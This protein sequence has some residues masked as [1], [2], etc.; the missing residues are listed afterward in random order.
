MMH[1]Q[2]YPVL[3]A[4]AVIIGVVCIV[5]SRS[6]TPEQMID[7]RGNPVVGTVDS[8]VSRYTECLELPCSSG[9]AD[10]QVIE[11]EG[12]T[13]GWNA[14]RNIPNWVAYELTDAEIDGQEGRADSFRPDPAVAGCPTSGDYAHSGYDR[15][16]MAPAA[17]MKWSKQAMTESFYLTNVC[18]QNHN[19]NSGDWKTLE[20][21]VREWGGEYASVCV[22]TG[23]IVT[24]RH[25]ETIGRNCSIVVPDAFFKAVLLHNGR[26][27]Q[28]IAF[29][30]NNEP[31]RGKHGLEHYACSVDEIET[32]TGLDL[33][34]N[35][36]DSIETVV[37]SKCEPSAF[38][39]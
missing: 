33:F 25:P 14:R 12:Y 35:L 37:E 20:E 32:V 18:P 8:V 13:V 7:G 27:W 28:A 15:G 31:R 6:H 39:L 3:V 23:P 36:P 4:V 16:H 30:M 21:K 38:G 24:S 1:R 26:S 11:H 17:D 2:S 22:C 34:C 9:D 29:R 10:E 19:L 5:R